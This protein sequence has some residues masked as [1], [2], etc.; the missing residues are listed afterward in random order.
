MLRAKQQAGEDEAQD[1]TRHNDAHNLLLTHVLISS[2]NG[3]VDG[4]PRF[5]GQAVSP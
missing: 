2:A 4:F 1:G 5:I 3:D